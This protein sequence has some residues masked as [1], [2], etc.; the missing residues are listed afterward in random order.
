MILAQVE[1]LK[2]YV[3]KG[4]APRRGMQVLAFSIGRACSLASCILNILL[5]GNYLIVNDEMCYF[6]EKYWCIVNIGH[7]SGYSAARMCIDNTSI[8]HYDLNSSEVNGFSHIPRYITVVKCRAKGIEFDR[9]YRN[10]E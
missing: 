7:R 8:F 9:V 4:P 2:A 6:T 3:V 10:R 5:N 1:V